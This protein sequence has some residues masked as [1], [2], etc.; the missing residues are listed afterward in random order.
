MKQHILNFLLV[1]IIAIGGILLI[2]PETMQAQS[3]TCTVEEGQDP[4]A[5]CFSEDCF[6][7]TD[8]E[9]GILQEVGTNHYVLCDK[10]S[11]GQQDPG[12]N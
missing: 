3:E 6:S 12:F 1:L 11:D 2:K 7:S 8:D 4:C 9:C 10:D 5:E